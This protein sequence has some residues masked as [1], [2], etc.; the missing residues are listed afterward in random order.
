MSPDVRA[1]S[2]KFIVGYCSFS[3]TKTERERLDREMRY[4]VVVDVFKLAK[5]VQMICA[6]HDPGRS[7]RS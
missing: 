6:L 4:V 2:W 1:N 3:S 7:M 5:I